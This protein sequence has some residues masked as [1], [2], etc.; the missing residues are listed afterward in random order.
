M[1]VASP[2]STFFD[3]TRTALLCSFSV[4]QEAVPADKHTTFALQQHGGRTIA[5]HKADLTVLGRTAVGLAIANV[6]FA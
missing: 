4:M 5:K 6:T 1:D 3:M 2:A